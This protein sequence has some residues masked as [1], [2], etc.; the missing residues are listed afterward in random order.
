M[1][2]IATKFIPCPPSE[3]QKE[4]CVNRCQDSQERLQRN[5]EFLSKIITGDEMWVHVYHPET[6]Q[7]SS[8]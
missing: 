6:K 4:N 3:K 1:R 8:Q 2:W 5:P 7:Q